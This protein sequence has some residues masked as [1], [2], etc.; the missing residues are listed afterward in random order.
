MHSYHVSPSP[1]PKIHLAAAVLALGAAWLLHL[2]L[3]KVPFQTWWIETPSVFGFYMLLLE[4]WDRWL[5]RA[6]P[7]RNVLC[8]PRID[9]EYKGILKSSYDN[10]KKEHE[11]TITILQDGR[12]IRARLQAGQSHSDSSF[13]LLDVHPSGERALTYLYRN[14]PNPDAPDTMHIHYGV[15]SLQFKGSLP[16]KLSGHYWSGR[17][18]M[19]HGL[20]EVTRT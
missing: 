11:V 7:H 2:A 20:I 14:E 8:I 18:R 3:D 19:N 1:L 10:F 9:G 16:T 6:R 12:S 4:I 13:A 17:G 5:W 15:C